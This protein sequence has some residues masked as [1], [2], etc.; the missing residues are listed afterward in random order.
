MNENDFTRV[1]E[2]ILKGPGNAV[3]VPADGT[4]LVVDGVAHK[5]IGDGPREHIGERWVIWTEDE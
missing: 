2:A 5:V 3:T 1:T 4:W